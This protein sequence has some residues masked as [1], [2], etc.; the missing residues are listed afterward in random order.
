MKIIANCAC[1]AWA[2][3]LAR[4]MFKRNNV[5][6]EEACIINMDYKWITLTAE[7]SEEESEERRFAIKYWIEKKFLFISIISVWFYERKK[8]EKLNAVGEIYVTDDIVD[9]EK[10]IYIVTDFLGLAGCA[11]ID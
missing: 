4:K 1:D 10:G 8:V 3:V 11:K 9:I 7:T 2:E 6:C 5:S